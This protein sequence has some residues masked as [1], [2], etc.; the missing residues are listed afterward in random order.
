MSRPLQ[1]YLIRHGATIWSQ[2]GRHTGQ[3][4]LPL[5]AMGAAAAT[6]LAQPL[7]A[8]AFAAVWC[9]PSQ[10]A[11]DTAARALPRSEVVV[12]EELSEWDYGEYEGLRSVDIRVRRPGWDIWRDGCPGGESPEAAA[13]RADRVLA[14]LGAR[15]RVALFTHGHFARLLALRWT[16]LAPDWGG[17]LVI[18]PASVGVLTDDLQGLGRPQIARWNWVPAAPG[19]G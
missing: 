6:A 17:N 12:N 5:T 13:A 9:S 1:V 2:L 3:T 10:R 4:D 8:V 19:S 14:G 16:G 15:G 11:R 18:D 7:A